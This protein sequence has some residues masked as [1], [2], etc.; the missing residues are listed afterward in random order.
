MKMKPKVYMLHTTTRLNDSKTLSKR[1]A[2]KTIL[3]EL[4][5]TKDLTS[6]R[7]FKETK[8]ECPNASFN[9]AA[10]MAGQSG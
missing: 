3:T 6:S 2:L 1:E 10:E 4:Y 9:L 7:L 5:I 8:G